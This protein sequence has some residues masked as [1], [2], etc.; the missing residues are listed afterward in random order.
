[1]KILDNEALP[2]FIACTEVELL[3]KL[4]DKFV[5]LVKDKGRAEQGF[6]ENWLREWVS[7][8]CKYKKCVE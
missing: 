6:N 2:E 1:M 7:N 8:R 5:T 4:V 3:V